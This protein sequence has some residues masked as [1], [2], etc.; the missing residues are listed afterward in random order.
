MM[1]EM[2]M[3]VMMKMM[4]IWRRLVMMIDEDDGD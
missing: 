3:M 4:V 1:K 2:N